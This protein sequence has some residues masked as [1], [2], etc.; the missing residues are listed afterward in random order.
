MKSPLWY[1]NLR[2]NLEDATREEVN[3]PESNT[4]INTKE[5]NN[6]SR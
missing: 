2:V 3:K 4:N 1:K 5:N 6:Y